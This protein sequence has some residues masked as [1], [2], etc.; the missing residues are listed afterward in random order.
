M[1]RHLKRKFHL[2]ILSNYGCLQALKIAFECQENLGLHLN[3]DLYPVRIVNGNGQELAAGERGDVIVSNLVTRASVFLN[4]RVGDIAAILPTPCPCGRTLPLLTYPEGRSYDFIR[5]PSGGIIHPYAL[6]VIFSAEEEV[7]QFQIVQHSERQIEVRLVAADSADPQPIRQR[8]ADK[9]ASL[10]G[11]E[12]TVDIR[13][14]DTVE[15]T[16]AG[17]VRLVI[18]KHCASREN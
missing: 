13:F 14:V 7:W 2:A 11:K 3:L 4:F 9:F 1:K 17:K 6:C 10:L 5:L 18:S 16:A 8:V 12:V 15:R